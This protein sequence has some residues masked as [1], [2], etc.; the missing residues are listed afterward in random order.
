MVLLILTLMFM[1]TEEVSLILDF[2][3]DRIPSGTQEKKLT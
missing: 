3:I 1:N 2:V